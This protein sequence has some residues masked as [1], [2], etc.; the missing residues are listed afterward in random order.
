MPEVPLIVTLE[1]GEEQQA[2]FNRKRSQYFPAHAN[3]LDAHITLFHRLPSGLPAIEEALAGFA[4]RPP[5]H[6]EVASV[7]NM[8]KGVAY[9]IESAELLQ[10]HKTMQQAFMP[11]LSLQDKRKRWPHITI[12][13]KVT[14]WKALQLYNTLSADFKP[15]HITATGLR[16]WLFRKGPW[17][18]K[19]DY[20]FS[21]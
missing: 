7:R 16:T 17:E 10:L 8:G 13:N 15:F 20:P 9:A 1:L 6:L 11:W 18:A 12:Q 19:N 21:L 5:M 2:F 14:A 4:A 3:F